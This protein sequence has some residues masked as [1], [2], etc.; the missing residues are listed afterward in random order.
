MRVITEYL[1]NT[2]KKLVGKKNVTIVLLSK[3]KSF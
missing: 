1:R 2:R 3:G